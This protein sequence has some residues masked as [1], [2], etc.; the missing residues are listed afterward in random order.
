MLAGRFR[1]LMRAYP[2][3]AVALTAATDRGP[4]A[5][6]VGSHPHLAPVG[7]GRVPRGDQSTTWPDIR[8]TA[9]VDIATLAADQDDLG[10]ALAAP[11]PQPLPGVPWQPSSTGVPVLPGVL[12]HLECVPAGGSCCRLGSHLAGTWTTV[13]GLPLQRA[14]VRSGALLR[15]SSVAAANGCS[16]RGLMACGNAGP[17]WFRGGRIQPCWMGCPLQPSPFCTDSRS[18]L[19]VRGAVVA[20]ELRRGRGWCPPGFD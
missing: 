15:A 9:R 8:R 18:R 12:A 4:P 11:G 19:S 1:E 20:F 2:T 3:G 14:L 17:A 10:A 16:P 6:L 13:A 7:A 5:L